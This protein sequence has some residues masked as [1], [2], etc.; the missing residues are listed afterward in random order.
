MLILVRHGESVLNK[1]NRLVG[2]LDPQLTELGER[3]A[4]AA[5]T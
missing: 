2:H 4:R 3:Q 5:K 1:E